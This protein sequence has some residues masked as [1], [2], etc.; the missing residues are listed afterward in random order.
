MEKIANQLI[1]DNSK[2]WL[3]EALGIS[4]VT[5]DTRLKKGN[6]KKL[7]VKMLLNLACT[8]KV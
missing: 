1:S 8:V 5:L 2:T 6:W 7:E 3:A 4:R